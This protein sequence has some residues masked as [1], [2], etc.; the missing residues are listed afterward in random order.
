M[1]VIGRVYTAVHTASFNQFV[2]YQFAATAVAE[3]FIIS[4][5]LRSTRYEFSNRRDNYAFTCSPERESL[6]V[7]EKSPD[8]HKSSEHTFPYTSQRT[9]L[10]ASP[11]LTGSSSYPSSIDLPQLVR[12]SYATSSDGRAIKR[13]KAHD[14]PYWKAFPRAYTKYIQ[15]SGVITTGRSRT[16]THTHAGARDERVQMHEPH[17]ARTVVLIPP[18]YL[19]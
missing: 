2:I 14:S 3:A 9:H 16:H 13:W 10:I 5:P 8:R 11:F 18:L 17:R 12:N 7:C 1:A 6:E 4:G 15:D 19:G